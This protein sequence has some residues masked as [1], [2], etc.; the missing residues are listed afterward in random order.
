MGLQILVTY[1]GTP[2]TYD[3]VMQEENVYQLR[4]NESA[5]GATQENSSIPAKIILRK[6]GMIWVSDSDNHEDLI[7]ALAHEINTLSTNA[8]SL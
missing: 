6:K 3:V 8:P 2:V 4:L 7:Q 5:S 1:R